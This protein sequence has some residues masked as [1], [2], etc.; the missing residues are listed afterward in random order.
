MCS[1]ESSFLNPVLAP[2]L[3]YTGKASLIE[4]DYAIVTEINLPHT[5]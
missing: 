5:S 3:L 2:G 1:A 4:H